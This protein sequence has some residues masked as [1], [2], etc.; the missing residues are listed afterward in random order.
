MKKHLDPDLL[1][2]EWMLQNIH[3]CEKK[4]YEKR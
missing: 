2:H 1:R 3:I 4:T